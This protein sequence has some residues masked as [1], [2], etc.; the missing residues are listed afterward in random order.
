MIIKLLR[1]H[2]GDVDVDSDCDLDNVASAFEK[3]FLVY[4]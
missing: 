3:T 4:P 1:H 2:Q